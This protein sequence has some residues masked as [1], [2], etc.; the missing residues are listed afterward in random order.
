MFFI[1]LLIKNFWSEIF[2]KT[3]ISSI[4][5]Y[6]I[7]YLDTVIRFYELFRKICKFYTKLIINF[8]KKTNS[9]K[10]SYLQMN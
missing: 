2:T 3:K 5:A 1:A 6:H 8:V 7:P 4:S 9:R 10:N